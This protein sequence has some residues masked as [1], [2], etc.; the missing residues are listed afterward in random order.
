MDPYQICV[1]VLA[2]ESI[3]MEFCC[4]QRSECDPCF[5][6]YKEIYKELFDVC[7]VCSSQTGDHIASR[8]ASVIENVAVYELTFRTLPFGFK[9]YDTYAES[10]D[11]SFSYLTLGE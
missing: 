11:I 10:S 1:L 5:Q 2:V 9:L 8:F 3:P 4:Q 6:N 7:F